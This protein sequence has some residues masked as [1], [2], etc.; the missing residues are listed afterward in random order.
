M[1]HKYNQLHN[2]SNQKLTVLQYIKGIQTSCISFYY[3]YM[4]KQLRFY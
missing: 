3:K 4:A 2:V 1:T